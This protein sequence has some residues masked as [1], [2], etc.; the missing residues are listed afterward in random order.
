MSR[1]LVRSAIRSLGL[2]RKKA[3]FYGKPK[4][5]DTKI[6]SFVQQR[7]AFAASGK[8]FVSIDETS[9]GRNFTRCTYGYSP[10]G[11]PLYLAK[12]LPRV[13]TTSVVACVSRDGLVGKHSIVGGAFNAQRFAAF[14][15]S[16]RLP[17][18]TVVLLD[19]VRFH[20]SQIVKQAAERL[21][22]HLLFVPP[23]SPWFNP[24]EYCFSVIKRA[25]YKSLDI[26]AA[27]GLLGART[28]AATFSKCL[29]LMHPP[30]LFA[31]T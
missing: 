29:S 24:I 27:F 18:D 20:H 15:E 14:L 22:I 10:I 3:S 31:A 26:E 1:E 19:N 2:S 23:Y 4:D 16:L 25:Y 5:L 8:H 21:G 9:F 30:S 13:T 28:C 17:V 6:A 12:A 11:K 7:D